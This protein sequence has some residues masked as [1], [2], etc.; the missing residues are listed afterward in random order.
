MP[1]PNPN[2]NTNTAQENVLEVDNLK[3]YFY[4]DAGVA[5]S[6]GGVSFSIPRGSTVALVGE[7]GCGKSVTSLSIMRL[8]QEPMGRIVSGQIRYFGEQGMIDLAQASKKEM[9]RIRGREIAMIFQE[10]MT[11]LNPVF[12]IGSQIDEMVSLHNPKL[13]RQQVRE[14][15]LETLRQVGIARAEGICRSYP[16]ELSG[17]M[18]QRIM[19]AIAVCC[20]PSLLIADEPTTALDV[21]IQAQI[22]ELLQDLKEKTNTSILLI[23]HDLGVV[24]QMADYVVVMYAGKVVE[25]GTAWQ[26]LLHPSHPYTIGLIRSKPVLGSVRKRLYSIPGTVP[27]PLDLPDYCPFYNRCE[28]RRDNC[29]QAMPALCQVED[30][31][32]DGHSHKAACFYA[33]EEMDAGEKNAVEP[34]RRL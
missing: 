15:T 29:R 10:P 16:H 1:N 31:S 34:E 26:V 25:E 32:G 6:V 12:T 4:T 3:T 27:S 28:R 33:G 30:P 7:S 14:I 5:R 19:I 9:Q 8:L 17:G 18:R 11:S 24:A 23:T 2:Q 22:L 21:T 13:T 20:K